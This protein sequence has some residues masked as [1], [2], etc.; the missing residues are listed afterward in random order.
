MTAALELHMQYIYMYVLN[1][2]HKEMYIKKQKAKINEKAITL[3]TIKKKTFSI[4]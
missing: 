3:S 4:F 1:R 2:K